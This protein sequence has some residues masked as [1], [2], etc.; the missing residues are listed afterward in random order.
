M[1]SSMTHLKKMERKTM[2]VDFF[3][4]DGLNISAN[5]LRY[6]NQDWSNG[7]RIEIDEWDAEK[8]SFQE[9]YTIRAFKQDADGVSA[10]VYYSGNSL[11]K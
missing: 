3:Y 4:G 1:N 9:Y 5:D 7:D 10:I 6:A 2:K 11:D 8:G